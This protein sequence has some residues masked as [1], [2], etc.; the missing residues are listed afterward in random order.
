VAIGAAVA[1]TVYPGRIWPALLAFFLAVGIG[2]HAFDELHDRPL[3]TR[4]SGRALTISGCVSLAA[5]TSI[6]VVG[7]VT[8]SITLA[9]LV[10]F[11]SAICVAYNLELFGG[12][13]HSDMWF[14]V[15]WGAFPAFT[16]YWVNALSFSV[17][18]AL[19]VLSCGVLSVA[20]R[21]LSTPARQL[22]R[23]T[24]AL[25]GEQRLADGRTI[26]LSRAVLLSPLDGALQ[27]LSAGV[28]LLAIGLLVARL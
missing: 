1:P 27:A 17:A 23:R 24:L 25:G 16:G 2:A 6:G 11:G 28:T 13:F 19:A 10:L 15:A 21:R 9:P 3:G 22:R 5:A 12:R 8:V 14:A 4:L 20:Q 26:E 7:V 18:G